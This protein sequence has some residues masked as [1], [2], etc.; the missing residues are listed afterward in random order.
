MSEIVDPYLEEIQRRLKISDYLSERGIHA[1]KIQDGKRAYCCPLPG[2]ENDNT[3]SFF[4]YDKGDHEDYW[5]WG[6]KRG[7]GLIS[8]VSEFE[9]ISFKD[10]ISKLG[11]GLNIDVSDI[12]DKVLEQTKK[13]AKGEVTDHQ[14]VLQTVMYISSISH[15]YFL[16]V[17]KKPEEIALFEKVFRICDDLM[18]VRDRK[19]L[20]DLSLLLPKHMSK[21]YRE[22]IA[23]QTQE[24]RKEITRW[25]L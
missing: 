8:F 19:A 1:A 9:S 20:E 14:S 10:A 22:I 3:P 4:V 18:K 13:A 25:Q 23:K 12:M 7:G 17:G 6:C 24:E 15:D 2:H 21:R 16:K 11:Y 5:C